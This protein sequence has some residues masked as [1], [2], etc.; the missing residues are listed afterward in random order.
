VDDSNT[1]NCKP[2]RYWVNRHNETVPYN[3]SLVILRN[4]SGIRVQNLNL[5]GNGN[6]ISL[7]GTTDSEIFGNNITDNNGGIEVWWS[8]NNSIIGN[9]ITETVFDGI[10]E[11]GSGH[12]VISNNLIQANENGIYFRTPSTHEVISD[13]QI[14]ANRAG[15]TLGMCSYSNVTD[16]LIFGNSGWGLEIGEGCFCRSK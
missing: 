9:R 13:N 2:I 14:V 8:F 5:T 4:C 11:Y 7:Y 3:T 1:V 16:N 10:E 15:G 6:G 12:N